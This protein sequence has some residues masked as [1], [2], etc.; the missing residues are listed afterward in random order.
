MRPV[1][2]ALQ[3][4][5]HFLRDRLFEVVA[6]VRPN[7]DKRYP[8]CQPQIKYHIMWNVTYRTIYN[9]P[10]LIEGKGGLILSLRLDGHRSRKR[11]S[12]LFIGNRMNIRCTINALLG[13]TTSLERLAFHWSGFA[14]RI[15]H[16]RADANWARNTACKSCDAIRNL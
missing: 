5:M 10:G 4:S 11:N 1:C 16:S 3:Q 6:V 15:W 14:S 7:S 2:W 8:G 13:C 9:C 12:E